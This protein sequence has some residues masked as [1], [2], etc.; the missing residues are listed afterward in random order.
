MGP[1][2]HHFSLRNLS[3]RPPTLY[4][5]DCWNLLRL[6]GCT[7]GRLQLLTHGG[8]SGPNHPG[9]KRT[10]PSRHEVLPAAISGLVSHSS[11]SNRP[12]ELGPLLQL[13]Q[14]TPLDY[15]RRV[16]LFNRPLRHNARNFP[17]SQHSPHGRRRRTYLVLHALGPLGC[18]SF[19]LRHANGR[20]RPHQRYLGE[21]PTTTR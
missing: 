10:T 4:P 3:P 7:L 9:Y 5:L 11:P 6:R 17:P 14:P 21:T 2:I 8:Q 16:S 13:L 18:S 20:T 15:P 19:P 1:S 12:L